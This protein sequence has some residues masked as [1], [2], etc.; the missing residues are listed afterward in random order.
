MVSKWGCTKNDQ[1]MSTSNLRQGTGR[2][3]NAKPKQCQVMCWMKW[4]YIWEF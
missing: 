3:K 2:H 1:K 4:F